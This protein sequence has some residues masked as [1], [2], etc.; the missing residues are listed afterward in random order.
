[1]QTKSNTETK[2]RFTIPNK[3]TYSP[4]EISQ[5]NTVIIK[6]V[7]NA[8]DLMN[9]L[10]EKPKILRKNPNQ[11]LLNQTILTQKDTLSYI[12]YLTTVMNMIRFIYGQTSSDFGILMNLVKGLKYLNYLMCACKGILKHYSVPEHYV[13]AIEW[14]NKKANER[15]KFLDTVMEERIKLTPLG[16][17]REKLPDGVTLMDDIWKHIDMDNT[18]WNVP[19]ERERILNDYF[20]HIM[21]TVDIHSE[22]ELREIYM[23]K[24]AERDEKTKR[25][26][27]QHIH[28][29]MIKRRD[30]ADEAAAI[31]AKEI[32]QL[33]DLKDSKTKNLIYQKALDIENP[34]L[35]ILVSAS[36]I[37]TTKNPKAKVYDKNMKVTDAISRAK[38]F[39]ENDPLPDELVRDYEKGKY[40]YAEILL[41]S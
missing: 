16:E 38:I 4:Y 32:K 2:I 18:N 7:K 27:E 31:I 14:Q 5:H 28:D 19:E 21:E 15:L 20:H 17:Y 3:K 26:H 39:S 1:M 30:L 13:K 35:Y 11:K 6:D 12:R 10:E 41:M 34:K 37:M 23:K 36:N 24:K 8:F 9:H 25:E 33:W 22:N 40:G 29:K